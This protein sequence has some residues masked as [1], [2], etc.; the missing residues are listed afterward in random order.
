MG[1]KR[2]VIILFLAI[3]L[4]LYA[5]QREIEFEEYDLD[6][7]LHVIL[8]QDDSTPIVAVS[9][10]YHVGSKNE[11]PDRTGFA[12][13]FEHLMFEGSKY[14]PTGEYHNIV[15][16]NGG[17]N[18][19]TTDFDRT[20]YYEILP[21]NQLA[22]GL[23]LESERMLHLKI[24]SAGV[25]T[26][27][28]VV[29]EERKQRLDNQPYG[30]LLEETFKHAYTKHPYHWTPIG[31]NQYIDKATID[32]FMKFYKHYYVPNN[33]VLTISGDIDINKAKK[34]VK[35]YFSDI[36]RGTEKITYPDIIEPRKTAEVRDTV[37]DNIQL[38]MVLMSYQIPKKTDPQS[39]AIDMLTT[40]LSGGQSARI[41]K[42]LVDKQQKAVFAGSVPLA[43]EDSGQFIVYAIAN[44]GVPAD[45][46]EKSLQEQIDKVKTKLISEREFKK[47]QN[48]IETRITNSN[49]TDAGLAAALPAYH[50]FYGNTNEINHELEKYMAVTREDIKDVADKFLKNNERVVLYYLPKSEEKK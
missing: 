48:Q 10:F 18:N 31:S 12:H 49:S 4:V 37:Y 24:D 17:T 3:S 28:K 36:P 20:Y 14:I 27:R 19:A 8:H 38:P 1:K 7:G 6:N 30:S 35:E 34:L 5:Q 33:A 25:E 16:S 40:L 21:S 29:K 23:W 26:Q 45:E 22:L 47:L 50:V 42:E 13:F 2:L 39:Y 41:Y 46:L 11:K 15:S 9:V 32:E 43:L 44:M